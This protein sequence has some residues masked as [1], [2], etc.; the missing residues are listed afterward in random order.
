M[1]LSHP[2]IKTLFEKAITFYVTGIIVWMIDL[3]FCHHIN[4]KENS[5]LPFNPQLHAVWHV[6]ASFGSYLFV[7]LGLYNWLYVNG[8]KCKIEWRYG[9]LVP[10]CRTVNVGNVKNVVKNVKSTRL[11]LGKKSGNK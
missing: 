2:S 6:L 4:G 11:S 10:V 1:K 3:H 5:I 9:G 8:Q 7:V